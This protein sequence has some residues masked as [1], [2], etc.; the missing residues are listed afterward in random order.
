MKP[1]RISAVSYLNTY[2][3]VYGFLKS[4]LP[5]NFILEL[6][7]PSVCAANLKSGKADI[8]LVPVGAISDFDFVRFVSDYCIGAVNEVRT[9]L[10]LSKKP[11]D[12][13]SRI[14]LDPDSRTSVLLAKVMASQYWKIQPEWVP[15]KSWNDPVDDMEAVVAIGDKTF[16]MKDQFLYQYDLASEWIRNTS[17]PFVFASWL[18]VRE[19]PAEVLQELNRAL[20]FGVENIRDTLRFF[21][22]KLP[23]S[24]EDARLYLEKNISYDFDL[25]KK[26]GLELFLKLSSKII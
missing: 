6:D 14:H 21:H 17:T 16:K 18:S 1:V 13:I 4:G 7:V 25:K 9:V 24:M 12:Q 26:K 2:P 5:D 19:Q 8:A 23:T 10:L 3:F 22:D 20:A 11:L 15:V